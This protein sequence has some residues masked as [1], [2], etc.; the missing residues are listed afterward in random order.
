MIL[1]YSLC[2]SVNRKYQTKKQT[3]KNSSKEQNWL[4]LVQ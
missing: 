3:V 2:D 4:T 1:I